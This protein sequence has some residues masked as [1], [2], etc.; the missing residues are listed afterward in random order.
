MIRRIVIYLR[1][2]GDKIGLGSLET[3]EKWVLL[4]GVLFLFGFV[5]VQL[6]ILPF[7]Q[8]R[9]NLQ[10]A[11]DRKKQELVKITELQKQYQQ[12]KQE[13]GTIEARVNQRKADF[14]LFE[15]RQ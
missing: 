7:F 15:G 3:R 6:V 4:A 5:C 9:D 8:A 14:T 2:I 10:Q 13:E 12:L 1:S 11:V